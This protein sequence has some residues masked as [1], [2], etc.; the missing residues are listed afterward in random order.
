MSDKTPG[1][2]ITFYSYKG[3][4]G[5]SMALANV[6]CLLAQ[7][8][9]SGGKVLMMDWDLEAP[10]LHRYFRDKRLAR[11]ADDPNDDRPGLI[12]LFYEIDKQTDRMLERLATTSG[13]MGDGK[14]DS[15]ELARATLDAVDLDKYVVKSGVDSLYLM[16]AG[17]FDHK[18][19][20]LY[21]ARVNTFRWEA[22][23]EKSPKLIRVLAERLAERYQY[24]LID[25]RTGITDISGIC[26]MLLPEKLV[27]VFTP[28]RQSLLGGL[29]LIE[30]ATEYRR[31]SS[32]LRPLVVFPL[33]S[34]VEMSKDRLREQWRFGNAELIGYQE[35]FER[36]LKEIYDLE[37][38]SLKDYFDELLIQQSPDYAYGE[39]IAVLEGKLED[40]FS[41]RRS[42]VN[43]TAKLVESRA[44]WVEG[45]EVTETVKHKEMGLFARL[46]ERVRLFPRWLGDHLT[47]VMAVGQIA[48]LGLAVVSVSQMYSYYNSTE[49]A[50][51]KL[52]QTQQMND[53]I[54]AEL[55]DANRKLLEVS[56]Y[57][58]VL[59]QN[60]ATIDL[61]NKQYADASVARDNATQA[62]SSM[63]AQ[64]AASQSA[65]QS[66]KAQLQSATALAN[67]A[68]SE[69]ERERKAADDIS[70]RYS[71]LL[72]RCT[73]GLDR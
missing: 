2:I 54:K 36:L 11:G 29:N 59:E 45:G 16:K 41:M 18:E 66:T 49:D 53:K 70:D 35:E 65:L 3:G 43:F 7:R 60:K 37:S 9:P 58:S 10:G 13:T 62:F 20:E 28:N 32:D 15:E 21:S 38:I 30:R 48:A 39:E 33:V 8:Q 73:G 44:P 31:E 52:Q 26:T 25:S 19:P 69:V 63:S 61:L 27:V 72:K 55:N 42:Y 23:Y 56:S 22:L 57:T 6:A 1:Q 47:K 5:R 50:T 68:Q 24:V 46:W 51:V 4:T 14:P 40:K 17:R 67:K 34:R 64:L 71:L 12:D